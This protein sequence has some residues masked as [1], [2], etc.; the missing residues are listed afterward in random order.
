[1]NIVQKIMQMHVS[2]I[3]FT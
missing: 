3:H 1:M 2:G